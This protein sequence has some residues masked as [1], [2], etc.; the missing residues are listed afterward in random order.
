MQG[1]TTPFPR[2]V[3]LNPNIP[4]LSIPELRARVER[5][6]Q[7]CHACLCII[8]GA[9]AWHQHQSHNRKHQETYLIVHAYIL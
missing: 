8:M 2:F 7:V 3:Q 1:L 6:K 9:H 5:E 4:D